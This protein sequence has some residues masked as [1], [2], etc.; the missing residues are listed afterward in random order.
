MTTVLGDTTLESGSNALLHPLVFEKPASWPF[1][2]K[3]YYK[4]V[5]TCL[6]SVFPTSQKSL[7]NRASGLL[8]CSQ[9]LRHSTHA[10]HTVDSSNCDWIN[11]CTLEHFWVSFSSSVTLVGPSKF[12]NCVGFF[13]KQGTTDGRAR[14][15]VLDITWDYFVPIM[16]YSSYVRKWQWLL[17][18]RPNVLWNS[19]NTYFCPF[20]K[21]V[22]T[23]HI[24]VK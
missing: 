20:I 24:W 3:S 16:T 8:V 7:W 14:W 12:A 22:E 13:S 1:T 19:T 23:I 6:F 5:I 17:A 11:G 2:F 15:K 4:T 10:W 21:R 18:I 9:S